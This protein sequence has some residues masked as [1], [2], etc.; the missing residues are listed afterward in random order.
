MRD[1]DKA[2]LKGAV[3]T[4]TTEY[5]GGSFVQ[6]QTFDTDGRFV[7]A[8][9]LRDGAPLSYVP[10]ES[11]DYSIT[12]VHHADGSR[13]DTQSVIGIDGWSMEGLSVALG[14]HGA[15]SGEVLAICL[16]R[17]SFRVSSRWQNRQAD[18]K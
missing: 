11:V 17:V 13:T 7:S 1:L 14:T 3:R 15:C 8:R 12:S 9:S 5:E 2:N 18:A 16:G 4:V 10:A 6:E